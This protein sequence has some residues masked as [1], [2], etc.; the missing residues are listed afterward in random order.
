ME[1]RQSLWIAA[2]LAAVAAA[3]ALAAPVPDLS[4]IWAHQW[5]PGFEALDSG[6]TAIVNLA[7]LPNGDSNI[8]QLVGDYHNPILKPAAAEIVRKLGEESKSHF[9]FH[10][11][12]NQCWPMGLPFVLSS[13]GM[14]IFDRGDHLTITYRLDH[15]V[16][17]VRMNAA[18]PAKPV[19][20][21]YGDSVGHYEG[22]TLV[23]D[24]IALKPGPFAMLDW[25]GTPQTPALHVVERYRLLDYDDARD[26]IRRAWRDNSINPAGTPPVMDLNYR[27]KWLQLLF[28]VDD[29]NVFTTPWSATVTYSPQLPPPKGLGIW[30]EYVCA[31]NP[32]KYGTEEDVQA[33]AAKIADF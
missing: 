25:F 22:D 20:S 29:P 12:R 23:I 26:G 7:R 9:G 13:D 5:D 19:P 11:P 27:G 1:V 14:Q 21:Y 18:H 2:A 28:T 32:Y 4:G 33:P 30:P 24:T 17:I 31:E 6:P 15:Q 16:R 3:P 10:N 8:A